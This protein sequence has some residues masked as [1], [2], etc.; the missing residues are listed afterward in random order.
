MREVN[1]RKVLTGLLILAL[2]LTG[3][4]TTKVKFQRLNKAHRNIRG[5]KRLAVL[6]FQ[7]YG[8]RQESGRAASDLLVSGLLG[9]EFYE[10]VERQRIDEIIAEHKFNLSGMVSDS[11]IRKMGRI[12]GVDAVI[13]GT[14]SGYKIESQR[15]YTTTAGY[16]NKETGVYVPPKKRF[17]TTKNG[18]VTVS[19]RMINIETGRVIAAKSISRGFSKKRY[20]NSFFRLPSDDTILNDLTLNVYWSRQK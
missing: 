8:G 6:D 14:V 13:F 4:A 9:P 1:M 17:Y 12:L 11:T 10:I 15:G 5:I 16:Y 20:D 7:S 2:F 19:Y 3:C 18:N